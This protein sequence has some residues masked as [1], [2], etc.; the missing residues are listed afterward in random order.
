[1]L[2]QAPVAH[3]TVEVLDEA[4]LVRLARCDVMPLDAG[5]LTSREHGATGESSPIVADH[6]ARQSAALGDGG[7]LAHDTP[8]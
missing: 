1:M 8:A 6:H 2:V 4:A 3:S 7:E 5:V